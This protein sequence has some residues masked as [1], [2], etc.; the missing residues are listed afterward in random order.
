MTWEYENKNKADTFGP[1]TPPG[2]KGKDPQPKK[3]D[4]TP[5]TPAIVDTNTV[6]FWDTTTDGYIQ[7]TDVPPWNRCTLGKFELPGIVRI[8]ATMPKLDVDKKKVKGKGAAKL[9]INGWEPGTLEIE[10]LIWTP[11]H[12][13]FWNKLQL[14]IAPENQ[15]TPPSYDIRCPQINPRINSVLVT[16]VSGIEDGKEVGTKLGKISCLQNVPKPKAT[17]GSPG[18]SI[19]AEYQE[20]ARKIYAAYTAFVPLIKSGAMC[21][22]AWQDFLYQ[23]GAFDKT[24]TL[25]NIPPPGN[26]IPALQG[27]KPG[28]ALL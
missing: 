18:S 1:W 9:T 26:Y 11:A 21:P 23:N 7:I 20:W 14:E 3:K 15:K 12:F 19:P 8:K 24:G 5:T 25:L 10:C 6:E 13:H 28:K 27:P 16:Y 17:G 2:K 22:I 4:P